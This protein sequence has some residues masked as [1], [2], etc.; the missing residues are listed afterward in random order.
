METIYITQEEMNASIQIGEI[1]ETDKGEKLRCVSKEN[2]E[3]LFEMVE[4]KFE[5]EVK[6]DKQL[7]KDFDAL[8][9]KLQEADRSRERSLAITKIQEAIMWLG[10]DLKRLGTENPY[11]E[12]KNPESLKI[13]PTAD[14]LKM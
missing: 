2:G 4:D 12:S 5:R 11:P 10:M 6:L 13:E 3:P 9:Q 7:R 14:G 1:I 8:L